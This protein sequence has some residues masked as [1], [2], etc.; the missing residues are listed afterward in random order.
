MAHVQRRW[1]MKVYMPREV[2]I[3]P[4]PAA[5]PID[6]K[7]PPTPAVSVTSSH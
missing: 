7:L 2:P 1:S 4:T 5:D 3:S 6:S